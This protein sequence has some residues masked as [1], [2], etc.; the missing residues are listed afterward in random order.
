MQMAVGTYTGDGNDNRPIIGIG[1]QPSAVLI[2]CTSEGQMPEF[3]SSA[4]VG[5]YS[6]PIA[7]G[8]PSAS[9][10]IQTLDSDGFTLG[11][12]ASVN[13]STATY[14][15]TAW[16]DNSGGDFH[17]GTYTG[18]GSDNRQITSVG[19]QPDFVLTK[20]GGNTWTSGVARW[21]TEVGDA[22][23]NLAYGSSEAAD[24]IQ[25][26]DTDGFTVGTAAG[27]N[28]STTVYYYLAFKNHAGYIKVGTYTGNGADNRSII[29]VGFQ[30]N[31]AL[32]R[33]SSAGGYTNW[34]TSSWVDDL[35][36]ELD[37]L[38]GPP[39]ADLV[40]ALEADGFQ[41]GA[42]SNVNWNT[43]VYQYIVFKTFA[44]QASAPTVTVSA[45]NPII[46][47]TATL[48]GDI[49][50][51]GGQNATERGFNLYSGGTCSG[52]SIQNPKD[53]GGSYNTGVFS[54]D[55]TS[56]TA[57]TQYSYTSYAINSGGSGSSSCQSFTTLSAVPILTGSDSTDVTASSATF[58][59]NITDVQG[60]EATERGFNIYTS[61][62]CS[63]SPIQSPHE[64]G[65]YGAGVYSL[66]NSSAMSVN[67]VYHYTAYA[68]NPEGTGTSSCQAFT[69][70]ANAPST[71]TLSAGTNSWSSIG[72]VISANNN[73]ANTTYAIYD[74]T[75]SKYTQ[76]DGSLGTSPVWQTAA[77]WNPSGIAINVTG[78]SAS[79]SYTFSTQAKNGDGVLAPTDIASA[80]SSSLSTT[81]IITHISACGTLSSANTTYILDNDVSSAGT[82]FT[83]SANG[84]ILDLNGHTVTYNT[85]A[86]DSV[87]GYLSAWNPNGARV[88]NGSFVQGAGNGYQSIAIYFRQGV[89]IEADHLSISYTGDNNEA[90]I[91]TNGAG[92]Q[93]VQIHDNVIHPNGTK[94]ATGAVYATIANGGSVYSV[95]QHVTLVGGTGTSAGVFTVSGVSSGGVVTSVSPYDN[96]GYTVLPPTS[97]CSVAEAGGLLL[98]VTY[99]ATHYGGFNT[100]TVSSTGNVDI[101][102]N[103]ID[104]TGCSGI[105][106]GYVGALTDTLHI[107]NNT[108][109][110]A[111]TVRDGY[112]ISIGSGSN[113]NIDFEIANN[114]IV[115]SSGRGI[116]VA[117]NYN[118]DSPGPGL[119][120]VHD[121]NIDVREAEDSGEYLRT[122]GTDVGIQL[123]FGA[124]DV[125]IYSNTITAH[126]GLNA[127]PSQ[128]PTQTGNDC[129]AEGIKVV[130]GQYAV[131]NQIYNNTVTVETTDA[132]LT[133]AGLYLDGTADS[134]STFHNNTVT[135]NSLIVD[136]N[137]PDGAGSN[138]N[139]VSNTFIKG[140]NPHGFNS[141]RAGYWTNSATENN[142]IDNNWQNGA[143]GDDLALA[144]SGGGNY[145]LY[146]KW[147]LNVN[148]QN[149]ST[150]LPISGATV[151]VNATGG[152]A[153]TVSGT[154]DGSG[155]ARLTLTQFKRYGVTYPATSNYNQYTPH[156]ITVSK[157]GFNDAS[158][159]A[160]MDST[161]SINLSMTSLDSS[162]PTVTAFSIPAISNSPTVPITTFTATDDI[163]VA[164]CMVTESSSAPASGDAGW[165]G[166]APSS[167]NFSSAGSKTLHAWAK[168][169][170]GNVSS[171]LSASVI[172][173]II[174]PVVMR[175]IDGQTYTTPQAPTFTEGT[176]TL[177]GD[178][179]TSGTAISA[180]GIYT[181]IVTDAA[182][183]AT[184]V[185]FTITQAA[186]VTTSSSSSHHHQTHH[187]KPKPKTFQQK[188]TQ[189]ITAT[190]KWFH[191]QS[192]TINRNLSLGSQGQDVGA[193]QTALQK[194]GLLKI[195]DTTYGVYKS[196]TQQAVTKLQQLRNIL[197]TGNFGTLTRNLFGW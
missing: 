22:S 34:R 118:A 42:S 170:A 181:L 172:I 65:N 164:G 78:L 173:D 30:P 183:N 2:V 109:K 185:S 113:D 197:P 93:S 145:S 19:F 168:D 141:I 72:V 86:G 160:T 64:N 151:T 45:A 116:L 102:N 81:A 4:M 106:F 162:A 166:S 103:D 28:Q 32:V 111:A 128:F 51:T 24:Q 137:G 63:G 119:G 195:K 149:S 179:Y 36:P 177:N 7:V 60:Q 88:T 188:F 76:A 138:F 108:I 115:Q 18:D 153:E 110:M 15:W 187:K 117:G 27:V 9:N 175:V 154:T 121:N 129:I 79:T 54:K 123:R 184:T 114:T 94:R 20:A 112:A 44:G 87:Y 134:S 192:V 132:T 100:I 136:A 21:S 147:Y 23:V 49:S 26:F 3:R 107:N 39:A 105:G 67:T 174:P 8:Q 155:N 125:Q 57:Q 140:T 62:D 71:P 13:K 146:T 157:T 180:I 5:D 59:G 80:L 55:I 148:V 69:T 189:K 96:G 48:H 1:F 85:A 156:T 165:T 97:N 38:G 75:D 193:L 41:I 126:A 186:I 25:S 47:T 190:K 82:C 161:K 169:A 56:L 35:T 104:G 46:T 182:N 68:T 70:L 135:S 33:A 91:D 191:K 95:G 139:V 74:A 50:D 98:N 176:A 53:T 92:G 11:T 152:A 159:Q 127:C 83:T 40:Q 158:T 122:P 144:G 133:A 84:T 124:H 163:A 43:K 12:N 178:P 37:Q 10:I 90:I 29:G 77:T 14:Q 16:K 17:I 61:S 150:S 66:S 31:A 6:I 99:G 171:S 73:P 194:L 89:N 58:N 120:T 130:G 143:S 101:Y 196:L 52:G 142:F 131:N 167:Y